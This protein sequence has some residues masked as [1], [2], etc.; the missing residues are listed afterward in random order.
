MTALTTVPPP[1]DVDSKSLLEQAERS[2]RFGKFSDAFRDCKFAIEKGDFTSWKDKKKHEAVKALIRYGHYASGKSE[3][4]KWLQSRK[5]SLPDYPLY[6]CEW[7]AAEMGTVS[8]KHLQYARN[9]TIK[10]S[11]KALRDILDA[12]SF[13]GRGKAADMCM[14][15]LVQRVMIPHERFK[16]AEEVIRDFSSKV[17][18]QCRTDLHNAIH[19]S[20]AAAASQAAA[21]AAAQKPAKKVWRTV[22]PPILPSGSGAAP[23][24]ASGASTPAWA[25]RPGSLLDTLWR[26]VQATLSNDLGRIVITSGAV[27][28]ALWFFNN[29]S[30]RRGASAAHAGGSGG[31]ARR[32]G[33]SWGASVPGGGGFAAW[34]MK[35]LRWLQRVV[36]DTLF[37]GMPLL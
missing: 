5:D 22:M 32:W 27:F 19:S 33:F 12:P 30:Q 1:L 23:R 24:D 20:R 37:A 16:D 21:Q 26:Q 35:A 29:K 31:V 4:M 13:P 18:V 8:K 17:S 9:D 11:D 14:E 2:Y 6:V 10:E 34:L 28:V 7:V 36:L 15:T 3:V 25:P